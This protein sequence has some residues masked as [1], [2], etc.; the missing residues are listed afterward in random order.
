MLAGGFMVWCVADQVWWAALYQKVQG[1]F[2]APVRPWQKLDIMVY[3][4]V[5]MDIFLTKM[6]RFCSEEQLKFF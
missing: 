1:H 2:L 3:K 4:V 6:H 5:N